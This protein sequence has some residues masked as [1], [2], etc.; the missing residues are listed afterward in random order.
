MNIDGHEKEKAAMRAFHEGDRKKGY[1]LQDEFVAEL[2]EALQSQDHCSCKKPC[3]YHGKC[4]E[5]VAIHRAH[6]EHLPNCFQ[7]MIN[8]RVA[9][10]SALTED[11]YV[12]EQM[13]KDS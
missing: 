2:R 1:A 3:K 6:R 10:I 9:A 7:S 12:K 8:E 4:V 5:C 13:A 11:S